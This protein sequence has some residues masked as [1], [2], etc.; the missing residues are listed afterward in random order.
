MATKTYTKF[1]GHRVDKT[2][3][4]IPF[5]TTDFFEPEGSTEEDKKGDKKDQKIKIS[6]KI[7]PGGD[8]SRSNVTNCEIPAITHFNNNVENV[9]SSISILKERVIK[10]KEIE[11]PN[12]LIKITHELLKL[13]C[14]G[15]GKRDQPR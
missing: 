12:E 2:T 10:P 1:K 14:T 9:L 8:E 15:T 6:I 7:R 4:H 5:Y 11:D 3:Y 13:I